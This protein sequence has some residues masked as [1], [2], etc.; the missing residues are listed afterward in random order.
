MFGWGE[1]RLEC[2]SAG[3]G[4]SRRQRG[5]VEAIA[6]NWQ[7]GREVYTSARLGEL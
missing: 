1:R 3:E 7:T 5:E 4:G 2:G 6:F